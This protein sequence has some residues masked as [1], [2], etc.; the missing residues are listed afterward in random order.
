MK[1]TIIDLHT[2]A[3]PDELAERIT[4]AIVDRYGIPNLYPCTLEGLLG[5]ISKA[6]VDS[7]VIQIFANSPKN[8]HR[9]NDWGAEVTR[10]Y[11]PKLYCFGTVHPDMPDPES[12]MERICRLG[13]RGV[14]FQPT[15]QRFYPD[16][17]K[18]FK[19]YEKA[20]K[21]DLPLLFHAGEERGPVEVL[22][23]HPKRFV[24]VL[25]S[26]PRLTLIL[27]HMGGYRMWEHVRDLSNY[28]KAYFDTSAACIELGSKEL[29]ELI[30]ILG[31]DRVL[32]GSDF[33]W[34]E[35][36][37]AMEAILNLDMPDE[38]KEKIMYRTSSKV[39][40]IQA[41]PKMVIN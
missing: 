39:L 23:T 15:A 3:F 13:L 4:K 17:R 9:L 20:E 31:R 29:L 32:F 1:T 33:P 27:A 16:D 10:N 40:K 24:Q 35:Y 41:S 18:L 36:E 5:T 22:Y 19:I 26:F 2:H 25:G 12:E 7:A 34:F 11:A 6:R 14:K 30:D 37:K 38:D 8:V 21:L 28:K